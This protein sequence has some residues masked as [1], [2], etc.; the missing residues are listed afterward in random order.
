MSS[1]RTWASFGPPA[2]L[3]KLDQE[4]LTTPDPVTRCSAHMYSPACVGPAHSRTS[5]VGGLGLAVRAR[6]RLSCPSMQVFVHILLE[7]V[8]EVC[9][10]HPFVPPSYSCLF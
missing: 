6:P 2:A 4:H 5:R 10:G 7:V 3:P 1:P 9:H 8:R